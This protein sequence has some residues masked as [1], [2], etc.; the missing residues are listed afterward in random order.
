VSKPVD[1][2]RLPAGRIE[3]PQR[4]VS[5]LQPGEQAILSL[6][7]NL[8][9]DEEGRVWVD[10]S[11]YLLPIHSATVGMTLRAERTQEG[12]ILWLDKQVKFRRGELAQHRR[13]LP[14]MEFREAPEEE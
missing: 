14:V 12:F 11:S 1:P 13:Y 7:M 9:T 6:L 8:K 5:E 4:K 2:P 10:M 3:P